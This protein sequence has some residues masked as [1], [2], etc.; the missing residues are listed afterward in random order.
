MEPLSASAIG[1]MQRWN[2]KQSGRKLSAKVGSVSEIP[3]LV[4]DL[5][6][7]GAKILSVSYVRETIG[8]EFGD[9]NV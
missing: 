8:K 6:S 9:K 4:E 3:D 5:V 7:A 1:K 2:I